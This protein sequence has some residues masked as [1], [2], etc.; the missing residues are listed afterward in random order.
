MNRLK[1][2][3]DTNILLLMLRTLVLTLQRRATT[4]DCPYTRPIPCGCPVRLR[5]LDL[6]YFSEI[7]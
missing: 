6:N 1:I 3:L 5:G 4:R 2:V 7:L